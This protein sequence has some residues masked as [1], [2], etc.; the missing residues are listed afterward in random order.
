MSLLS[1]ASWN[2]DKIQASLTMKRVTAKVRPY[3]NGKELNDDSL[4]NEE[5][6]IES[7]QDLHKSNGKHLTN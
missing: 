6:T 3:D 7:M 2:N 5:T 1:T 4:P